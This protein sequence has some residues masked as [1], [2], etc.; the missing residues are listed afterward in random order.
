MHQ[1]H[2]NATQGGHTNLHRDQAMAHFSI[3]SEVFELP[4]GRLRFHL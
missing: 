3:D 2:A 1:P 4:S